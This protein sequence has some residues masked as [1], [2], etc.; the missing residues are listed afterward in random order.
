MS[1]NT[2]YVSKNSWLTTLAKIRD[3]K[4]E[5]A[6]LK[7]FQKEAEPTYQANEQSSA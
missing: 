4:G 5:D 1:K 6:V 2:N 7:E 3:E